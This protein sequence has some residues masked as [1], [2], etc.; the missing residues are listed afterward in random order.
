[1]AK[2]INEESPKALV[3]YT[4]E[5]LVK[6]LKKMIEVMGLSDEETKE[7]L[8]V[9]LDITEEELLDQLGEA[10]G[11][12]IPEED[13]FPKH[14]DEFITAYL[15][16]NNPEKLVEEE[17]DLEEA[18]EEIQKAV[19]LKDL[20]KI[21]SSY[22]IFKEVDKKIT[23][24]KFKEDLRD[25]LLRALVPPEMNDLGGADIDEEVSPPDDLQ[26]DEEKIKEMEKKAPKPKKSPKKKVEKSAPPPKE[27]EETPVK[28]SPVKKKPP[29]KAMPHSKSSEKYTRTR[30]VAETMKNNPDSS[31]DDIIKWADDLFVENGGQPNIRHSRVQYNI[32]VQVLKTFE[33]L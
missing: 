5:E 13:E 21:A 26:A 1:M 20:K 33:I 23:T 6:I 18:L 12:I 9:P 8:T 17:E 24:Y 15:Q 2:K 14:I 29:I 19:N 25:D 22:K 27:P 16:V 11:N 28:P 31:V 32:I 30:A 3:D 4:K 7:P 10:I